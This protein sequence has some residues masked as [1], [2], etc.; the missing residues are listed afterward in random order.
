MW[1]VA[2]CVAPAVAGRQQQPQTTS[3]AVTARILDKGFARRS[4]GHAAGQTNGDSAI[5][6]W[7]VPLKLSPRA[8]S[9]RVAAATTVDRHRA[10]ELRRAAIHVIV[11]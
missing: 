9:V 7:I 3:A 10:V 1:S 4:G 2:V 6:R 8:V 11:R 5:R